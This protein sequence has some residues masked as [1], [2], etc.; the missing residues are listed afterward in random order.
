MD[1]PVPYSRLERPPSN[2]VTGRC[3]DRRS[4]RSSSCAMTAPAGESAPVG[5][6]WESTLLVAASQGSAS[7]PQQNGTRAFPEVLKPHSCCRTAADARNWKRASRGNDGRTRN[8]YARWDR[9]ARRSRA[10]CWGRTF[11]DDWSAIELNLAINSHA[12]EHFE[13]TDH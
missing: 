8:R 11:R 6:S 7:S 5:S 9:V 10:Q 3:G 13:M 1:H 4:A 2:Y 12:L